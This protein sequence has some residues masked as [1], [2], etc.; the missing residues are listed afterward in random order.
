MP[1]TAF[2]P[3]EGREHPCKDFKIVYSNSYSNKPKLN[4]PGLT[5]NGEELYCAIAKNTN[6]GTVCGRATSDGKCFY[7]IGGKEYQAK[8]FQ[9]VIVDDL[10]NTTPQEPGQKHQY[11]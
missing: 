6:E 7:G 5:N 2:Y 8:D 3:F 1:E 4:P 10:D 11:P 9:Y